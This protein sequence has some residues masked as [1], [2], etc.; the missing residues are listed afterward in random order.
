MN[1]HN[2]PRRRARHLHVH[3]D[4]AA[5]AD[6]L[7]ALTGAVEAALANDPGH[8][9]TIVVAVD[10]G[11][12]VEVRLRAL[13]HHPSVELEGLVAPP[14]WWCL[15]I[16]AGAHARP[17]D[18]RSDPAATGVGDRFPVHLA[19]LV[20]RSGIA[21]RVLRD[22]RTDEVRVHDSVSD[23]PGPDG[24][25]DRDG[26]HLD[27]VLRRALGVATPPP[28]RG[29]E[30]L[31]AALW[32][33]RVM[34]EAALHRLLDA[35]WATVAALHP[36]VEQLPPGGD[37][38]LRDWALTHLV[39]AGE[40][41]AESHP[42]SRVRAAAQLGLGPVGGRPAELA[43]WLD[44]GAFARMAMTAHGPLE[45]LLADLHELLRPEVHGSLLDTVEAWGLLDGS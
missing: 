12:D 25:G 41:L 4:A 22:R 43:G 44:D 27:D 26:G 37:P 24:P 8:P 32:V 17:L 2:P 21:A 23:G 36:V 14:S 20:A 5:E 6:K 42:W 40:L 13:E 28:S 11:D 15:G 34:G 45:D 18:D 33:H 39:R 7:V 16:V 31:F 38:E 35:P 29:T 19:H 9:P 3:D 1:T 10:D 30:E